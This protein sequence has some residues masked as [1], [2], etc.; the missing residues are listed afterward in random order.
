MSFLDVIASRDCALDSIVVNSPKWAHSLITQLERPIERVLTY[1]MFQ[2]F[3]C[4]TF[5]ILCP[6]EG[7][8]HTAIFLANYCDNVP[9]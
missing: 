9:R 4:I 6:G 1:L 5:T 3:P 7:L 8:A 2:G